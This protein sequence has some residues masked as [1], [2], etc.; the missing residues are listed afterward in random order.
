MAADAEDDLHAARGG[1]DDQRRGQRR[2][3][4]AGEVPLRARLQGEMQARCK[5]D[6]RE[7]RVEMQGD[8][9]GLDEVQGEMPGEM[10]MQGEM[11]RRSKGRGGA[12]MTSISLRPSMKKGG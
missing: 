6:A 1:G 2:G 12:L 9:G 8:K 11:Q 3:G 4:F 5:G 7:M 10:K